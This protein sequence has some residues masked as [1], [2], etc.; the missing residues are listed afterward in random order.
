MTSSSG[1]G[2]GRDVT[3]LAFAREARVSQ[4]RGSVPGCEKEPSSVL[5]H[6]F[7]PAAPSR[8]AG[9]DS[10]PPGAAST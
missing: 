4:K 5:G 10:S 8:W 3:Q 1:D 7:G 6:L 9:P 2:Q